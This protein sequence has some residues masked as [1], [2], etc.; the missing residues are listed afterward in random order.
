MRNLIRKEDRI[1]I[2]APH[3]DDESIGCGGLLSLYGS[4]CDV[5]VATDGRGGHAPGFAGSEEE[6]AGIRK[7]ELKAA[8]QLCHARNVR[9]L[10]IPDGF[11]YRN[12]RSFRE[13]D[14]RPYRLIFVPNRAESHRDHRVVREMACRL[15]RRQRAR[16]IIVEYE[17]WTPMAEVSDDLDIS[18]VLDEKRAL[19]SEYQSQIRDVDYV[20]RTLGLN[21]YRGIRKGYAYAEAYFVNTRRN[22]VKRWF[23]RLPVWLQMQFRYSSS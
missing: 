2:I 18:P 4:Q 5:V 14:L 16:G 17:V 9:F 7:R 22:E 1:L 15:K 11:L 3:P 12:Y 19:I 6:L 20:G 23:H 13:I 8:M 21:C 10:D